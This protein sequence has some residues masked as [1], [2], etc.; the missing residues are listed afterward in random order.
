M[1]DLAFLITFPQTPQWHSLAWPISHLASR[2]GVQRVPNTDPKIREMS[3][4]DANS[5]IPNAVSFL[6]LV[7]VLRFLSGALVSPLG[8]RGVVALPVLSR[9]V[10]VPIRLGRDL[11]DAIVRV[12]GADH[13]VR[14]REH[15]VDIVCVRLVP[16]AWL[17]VSV[18]SKREVL[19]IE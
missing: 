10:A 6:A 16:R 12:S 2:I 17:P 1:L 13:R 3:K 5:S 19:A 8:R 14:A 11:R 15:F 7:A 9:V 4:V 18:C